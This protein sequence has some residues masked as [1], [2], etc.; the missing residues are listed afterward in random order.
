MESERITELLTENMKT[1]FG[2]SLTRLQDVNEAEELT[3]DILYQLVRSADKLE[4][5]DRFYAYMWS[6]AE[7]VYADYIRKK[8]RQRKRVAALDDAEDRADDDASALDG[9]IKRES[10]AA[11]RRELSLLSHRYREVVVMHYMDG[12]TCAEIAKRLS[13]EEE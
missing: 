9:M 7:H 5:P 6:T 3:S 8:T 12:R 13:G 11:L 1:V 2:F 10:I 4:D